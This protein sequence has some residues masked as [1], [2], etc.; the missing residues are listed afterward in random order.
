[1]A[2]KVR[3]DKSGW[4]HPSFGRLGRGKFKGHVYNLPDM[5]GE[6]ETIKVPVMDRSS[7]PPR[8]IGEQEI[9]RNK[10]LPSTAEIIDEDFVANLEAAADEGDE[11]ANEELAAI[12]AASRPKQAEGGEGYLPGK[13]RAAKAQSAQE[14]TTGKKLPARSKK[15]AATA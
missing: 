7:R 12:K 5:F 8:K 9:T 14:R 10:Y 1:M 11:H 15:A 6:Q 2:I 3:F 13:G 4:H